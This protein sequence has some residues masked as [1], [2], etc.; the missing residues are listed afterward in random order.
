MVFTASVDSPSFYSLFKAQCTHTAVPSEANDGTPTL[1][2][3]H[4]VFSVTGSSHTAQLALTSD[5][6]LVLGW[7]CAL[8]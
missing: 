3:P 7:Q 1:F 4:F 5:P 6:Y 2:H 8:P